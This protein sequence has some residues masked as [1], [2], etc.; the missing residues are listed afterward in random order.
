MHL[1]SDQRNRVNLQ[2]QFKGTKGGQVLL[3]SSSIQG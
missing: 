1:M 3:F 2:N